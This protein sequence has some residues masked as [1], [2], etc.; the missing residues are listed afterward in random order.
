MAVPLLQQAAGERRAIDCK[1]GVSWNNYSQPRWAATDQ[2]NIK[3]AIEAAGGEY[4]EAFAE[5]D[6]TQQ[7]TDVENLITRTSMS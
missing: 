4:T 2:P 6:A 7:L 3:S 1:V 5:D